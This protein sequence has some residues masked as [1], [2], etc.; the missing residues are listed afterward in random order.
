M[1]T[2]FGLK[3]A[4]TR[5]VVEK[6]RKELLVQPMSNPEFP[7]LPSFH[8][9][10]DEPETKSIYL[11]LCWGKEN[12]TFTEPLTCA[13]VDRPI[14]NIENFEFCG[15][16][17]EHQED[18]AQTT[19]DHL[20]D[21]E[22]GRGILCLQTGGGK[23]FT[24]LYVASKLG[25]KTLIVVN[26]RTL[27]EQW[28]GEIKRFLPKARVGFLWQKKMDI[29][30]DQEQ[31]FDIILASWQTLLRRKDLPQWHGMMII[32][33]CHRVCSKEFSQIMFTVNAKHVLGLSAT[34]ER[35]DGLTNVLHWHLGPVIVRQK[36]SN[37][38]SMPIQVNVVSCHTA[39]LKEKFG[40]NISKNYVRI[41]GAL[42]DDKL[43]TRLIL[44]HVVRCMTHKEFGPK[45]R[46]LV[47]TERVKHAQL[48]HLS[49]IH[50]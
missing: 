7:D 25:Q 1:I 27:L 26:K 50:I 47:L 23:T 13:L 2:S 48:L 35:K 41:I 37:R 22:Q 11:P 9:F 49:L 42:V 44:S 20:N 39:G 29:S 17:R 24:S 4:R 38:S 16:L 19:I 3:V 12:L 6:C 28:H 43:R 14:A 31:D 33:E 45:R 8:V 36:P 18:A 30:E 46:V 10:R 15:T 5:T 21:P 32:D 34:P 40:S